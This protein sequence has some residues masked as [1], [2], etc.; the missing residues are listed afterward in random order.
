MKDM[1]KR[2]SSELS[3]VANAGP[4]HMEEVRGFEQMA[5]HSQQLVSYRPVSRARRSP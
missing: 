3:M 2:Q 5:A 1:N 4:G